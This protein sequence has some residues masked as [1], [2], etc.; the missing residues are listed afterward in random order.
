MSTQSVTVK[1]GWISLLVYAGIGVLYQL[2][3]G[4][5]PFTWTDPWTWVTMALWPVFLA[6]WV[7]LGILG[8][9]TIAFLFYLY[10]DWKTK[11]NRKKVVA[12]RLEEREERRRQAAKATPSDSR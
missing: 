8:V 3:T 10:D 1:L 12:R 11:K 6:G 5:G 9:L 4:D 2:M 7:I